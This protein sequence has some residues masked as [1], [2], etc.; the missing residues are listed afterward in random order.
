MRAAVLRVH[1]TVS[2]MLAVKT[3]NYA[4]HLVMSV[5]HVSI[6]AVVVRCSREFPAVMQGN[7]IKHLPAR[8]NAGAQVHPIT[9]NVHY[10]LVEWWQTILPSTIVFCKAFRGLMLPSAGLQQ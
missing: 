7:L 8:L 10:G 3:I 5:I 9:F 4:L 1:V 2:S 6:L